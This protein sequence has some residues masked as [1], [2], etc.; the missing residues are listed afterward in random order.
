DFEGEVDVLFI[1]GV[2]DGGEAFGEVFEAFVP[3]VLVGGRE[4]V[5]GVPNAGTG[6]T[7][8]DPGR[9]GRLRR[10]VDELSAG[11]GGV[12]HFFGGALADAFGFTVA[13]DIRW[14]D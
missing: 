3:V 9:L 5:D 10:R 14:E 7:V 2:E 8:D 4:G 1:E 11:F 12:D 13:P 6:E